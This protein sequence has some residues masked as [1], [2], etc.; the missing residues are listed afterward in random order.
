MK[1]QSLVARTSRSRNGESGFTLIELLTIIGIIGVLSFL[2]LSSFKVYRADAAY[3]VAESTLR[4]A[5]SSVEAAISNVDIPPG[6]VSLTEQTAPGPMVDPSARAF[7]PAFQIPK[8]V[9]F[10]VSYDPTCVA[11]GCLSEFIEVSHCKSEE[12]TRWV[13]FGD[14]VDLLLEHVGGGGC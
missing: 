13:R 8:S 10:Q 9:K 2:G 3:S 6:A 5:R 12:F 7:L 11:S 14:G 1:P 4:T